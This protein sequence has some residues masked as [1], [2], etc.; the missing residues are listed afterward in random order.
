MKFFDELKKDIK[1]LAVKIACHIIPIVHPGYWVMNYPYN[2][3][4]DDF[5]IDELSKPDFKFERIELYT[6]FVAG[7]EVWIGNHPYASFVPWNNKT[8]KKVS[9]R[10]S[11]ATIVLA[12][13]ALEK[14]RHEEMARL[15]KQAVNRTQK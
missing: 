8:F 13:R 5:L 12:G 4:W 7:I 1:S 10:P 15:I 2:K 11:R 14:A 6:A 9:I 3:A